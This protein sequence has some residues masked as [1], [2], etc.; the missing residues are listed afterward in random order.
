MK[1]RTASWGL[2]VSPSAFSTMVDA[3]RKLSIERNKFCT[4]NDVVRDYLPAPTAELIITDDIVEKLRVSAGDIKV[5]I[6]FVGDI[7]DD[8]EA[9]RDRL[10]AQTRLACSMREVTCFCCLIILQQAG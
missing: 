9:F 6:R 10:S 7:A 5:F 8:L 1:R 4:V 2:K 3:V